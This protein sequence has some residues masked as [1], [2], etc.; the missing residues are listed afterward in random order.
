MPMY[1][2]KCQSC[3]HSFEELLLRFSDPDP[4]KCENCKAKGTVKRVMGASNFALK[5]SCWA[6]DGYA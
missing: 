3:Q 1:L 6:K 5:G 4:E 2:Y